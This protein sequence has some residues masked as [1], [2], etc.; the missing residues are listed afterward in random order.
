MEVAS[1]IEWEH[2]QLPFMDMF[3]LG[4]GFRIVDSFLVYGADSGEMLLERD[5]AARMKE[6]LAGLWSGKEPEKFTGVI[7]DRCR[8]CF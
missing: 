2:F 6:G 8:V 7:S 5:Q 3:L 4:L 1:P